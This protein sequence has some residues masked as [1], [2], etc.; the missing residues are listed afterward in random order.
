VRLTKS[1]CYAWFGSNTFIPS[2]TSLLWHSSAGPPV[3]LTCF[4]SLVPNTR[5]R[6]GAETACARFQE[7]EAAEVDDRDQ[8]ECSREE[9]N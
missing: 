6:P 3:L 9:P 8:R 7:N 4:L 2:Q 5:L 1:R